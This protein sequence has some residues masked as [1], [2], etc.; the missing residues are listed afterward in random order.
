[1]A[2][3]LAPR[4][5]DPQARIAVERHGARLQV[6][7]Q[8]V[9]AERALRHRAG[10]RAAALHRARLQVDRR[11]AGVEPVAV[12][13]AERDR[14]VDLHLL[15]VHVVA[16][17]VRGE[18]R[19]GPSGSWMLRGEIVQ[20]DDRLG[21]ALLDRRAGVERERLPLGILRRD[22]APPGSSAAPWRPRPCSC[23]ARTTR[24]RPW[25]AAPSPGTRPA[26]RSPTGSATRA[27]ADQPIVA[28]ARRRPALRAR[29]AGR[30]GDGLRH[31]RRCRSRASRRDRARRACGRK[32]K[33]ACASSV[34]PSRASRRSSSSRSRWRKRTSDAA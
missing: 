24:R 18:R 19:A 15:A 28:A 3:Y 1:M 11:V 7:A 4:G 27:I 17:A 31:A 12:G 10:H 32:S 33:H 9:G 6:G 30:R 21:R 13:R 8:P 34:R 16:A 29:S 20:L 14:A 23:R 22:T 25:S 5:H 26:R 2:R